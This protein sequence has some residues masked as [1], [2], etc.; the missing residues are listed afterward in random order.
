MM[1]V[2]HQERDIVH[3]AHVFETIPGEVRHGAVLGQQQRTRG[4][5]DL[6]HLHV[7]Q[8]LP[9][10]GHVLQDKLHH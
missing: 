4:H 7:A 2:G 9:G 8:P 6:V 3:Q 10:L 1:L 5:V